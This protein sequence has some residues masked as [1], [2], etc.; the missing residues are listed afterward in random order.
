MDATPAGE[1]SADR[2]PGPSLGAQTACALHP[3]SRMQG[4]TLI[5]LSLN[6][7]LTY[8]DKG[9]CLCLEWAERAICHLKKASPGFKPGLCTCWAEAT[10]GGGGGRGHRALGDLL[11]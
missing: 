8:I 6:T 1:Q 2:C 5:H 3:D 10:P 7:L 4:R 11:R 9:T